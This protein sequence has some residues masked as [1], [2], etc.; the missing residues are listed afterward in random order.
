MQLNLV[1]DDWHARVL[2][3]AAKEHDTQVPE[4]IANLI[5]NHTLTELANKSE[6]SDR[7]ELNMVICF[8]EREFNY[9]S[10]N[11]RK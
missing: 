7:T 8:P 4:I 3:R 6:R 11:G 10:P 1:I 2:E 9:R 5:E